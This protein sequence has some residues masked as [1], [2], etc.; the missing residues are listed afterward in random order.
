MAAAGRARV[1]PGPLGLVLAEHYRWG[2]PTGSAFTVGDV[3]ISRDEFASLLARHPG[4]LDHEEVH[5]RQWMWCCGLP[6]IPLYLASMGLS[7]LRTGDRAAGCLFERQAGLARGGY[8]EAPVRPLGHAL[9]QVV[10]GRNAARS[11]GRRV[12]ASPA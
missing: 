2:F 12:R 7:W 6:F 5:A 8:P 9:R 4:L 1:R 3:V 10:H 11:R